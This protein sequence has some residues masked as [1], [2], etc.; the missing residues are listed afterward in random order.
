MATYKYPRYIEQNLSAAF[1]GT[2]RPGQVTPHSGIYRCIRCGREDVSTEGHPLPPQNHHQHTQQQGRIEWRLI[3]Y[4]DHEP[5]DP[6][7]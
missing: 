4:A 1:D 2:H 3:V 5:K 7:G 6:P